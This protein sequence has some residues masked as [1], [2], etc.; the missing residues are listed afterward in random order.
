[1]RAI[2]GCLRRRLPQFRSGRVSLQLPDLAFQEFVEHLNSF[3]KTTWLATL[4]AGANVAPLI[5][6]AV[7]ASAPIKEAESRAYDALAAQLPEPAT[8]ARSIL[9]VMC[10]AKQATVLRKK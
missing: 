7:S 9:I 2:P 10:S 5:A 8:T 1:V 4:D 6:A 3:D